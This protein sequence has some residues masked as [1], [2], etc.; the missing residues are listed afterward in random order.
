MAGALDWQENAKT[1]SGN[2]LSAVAAE[3]GNKPGA[4][5]ITISGDFPYTTREE[6]TRQDSEKSSQVSLKPIKLMVL[7]V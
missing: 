5:M 6:N 3:G 1:S 7:Q 4:P 2:P